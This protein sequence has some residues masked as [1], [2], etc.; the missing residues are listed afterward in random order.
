M[1][2]K[3]TCHCGNVAF[4]VEGEL[5]RATACNCSICSRKDALLWFAPR[6]PDGSRVAAIT[7]RCLDDVDAES[8]PVDHFD[9]RSL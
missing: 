8:V 2:Y 5:E 6:G 1:K 3:S 7:V 9:G 4:E